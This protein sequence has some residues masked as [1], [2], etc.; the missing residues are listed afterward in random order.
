MASEI[1]DDLR[2]VA[3]KRLEDRRGF[4]PHLL[5]YLLVNAGLV[6]IWAMTSQGF[7]WPGLVMVFWG[8]AVV[9]HFWTAFISRPVTESEVE[10]EV[11][12]LGGGPRPHPG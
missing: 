1:D 4:V 5:M 2:H 10:R 3:R 6:W 9:M 12:R 8:I 7:F 11:Q